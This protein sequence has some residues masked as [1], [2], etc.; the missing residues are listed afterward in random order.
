MTLALI[1]VG[2][3]S[4]GFG[5]EEDEAY[6]NREIQLP[7]KDN[8]TISSQ[9][10]MRHHPILKK[11]KMHYGLDFTASK[12]TY[13]Y[14][15]MKGVV[16]KIGYDSG[17]GNW[18]E[19]DHQNGYSSRY[20]HCYLIYSKKNDEVSLDTIIASVGKTGMSTGYHLHLEVRKDGAIMDPMEILKD[21]V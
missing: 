16:T 7:L 3:V 12:G 9:Y 15:V 10:G 19:I 11:R 20:L 2:K 17:R 21:L 1:D 14:P 8:P 13:I 18:I 4:I 6:V 5:S